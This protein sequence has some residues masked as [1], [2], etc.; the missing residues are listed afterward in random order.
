MANRHPE[1]PSD[2]PISEVVVLRDGA[3]IHRQPCESEQE[4][5][6][7]VAHWEEQPGVECE[8]IDLTAGP[9]EEADEIDWVD[10][11]LDFA[12]LEIDL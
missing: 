9:G 8:V 3:E 1:D 6:A 11:D 2:T 7:I 12:P 5:A 4:A 10:A